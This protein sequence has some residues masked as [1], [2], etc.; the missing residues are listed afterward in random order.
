ME[1]EDEAQQAPS[2]PSRVVLFSIVI[3]WLFYFALVTIRSVVLGFG[4]QWEML[5]RRSVVTAVSTATT[6][7]FYLVLRRFGRSSLRRSIIAASLLAIPAAVIYSTVNWY[8]FADVDAS[9]WKK[10][11]QFQNCSQ[12]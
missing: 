9:K 10:K 8:A 1:F 6:W 2:L 3:F 11:Q 4:D 5:A 12:S 7:V